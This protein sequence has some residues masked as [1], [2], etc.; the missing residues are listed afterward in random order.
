MVIG[1]ILAALLP[2]LSITWIELDI[3]QSTAIL[4]GVTV[5]AFA[6]YAVPTLF[7]QS[8]AG[9]TG[10]TSYNCTRSSR[11]AIRRNQNIPSEIP[12]GTVDAAFSIERG[13]PSQGERGDNVMFKL[14]A[15]EQEILKRIENAEEELNRKYRVLSDNFDQFEQFLNQRPYGHPPPSPPADSPPDGWPRSAQEQ[16]PPSER[17]GGLFGLRSPVPI[18]SRMPPRGEQIF[19]STAENLPFLNGDASDA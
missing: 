17:P 18:Q 4:F 9:A 5:G 3:P 16:I 11:K 19:K 2:G 13:Q 1:F 6:V 15:T 10:G 7:S 14:Q 12:H 8:F